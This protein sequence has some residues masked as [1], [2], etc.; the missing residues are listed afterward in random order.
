MIREAAKKPSNEN[1]IHSDPDKIKE[2]AQ[3][4]SDPYH[5]LSFFPNTESLFL[6]FSKT[7]EGELFLFPVET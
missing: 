2:E 3:A 4:I 6:I 7:F 5:G 1:I